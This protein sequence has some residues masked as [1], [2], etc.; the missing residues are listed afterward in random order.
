MSIRTLAR[1]SGWLLLPALLVAAGAVWFVA[2]PGFRTPAGPSEASSNIPQDEFDRRVRAYI[3]ENPEVLV[4]AMQRLQSRQRAAKASEAEAAL[5]ARADEVFRD[6]A[7]P[8]GGIPDGNITLVVFFDYNCPYCRR[9]APVM[10]EAETADSRLRIVY[11]EFPILGPNSLY[12]A[13]AALAAH[14]Q[15]CYVAFHKALMQAK[16]T[17]HAGSVLAVAA[18][19]GLDVARIRADMED[20]AIQDAIDRNL[21]LRITG[22]PGFVVGQRILRGATDLRTLQG[23]IREARTEP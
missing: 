20:L 9:V 12:A 3:L 18:K 4:E 5:D 11:K 19:V 13:K 16:G 1:K 21:A 2:D 8:V 23:L 7:S 6:A 17:A 10:I 22:T 15:G 14:R